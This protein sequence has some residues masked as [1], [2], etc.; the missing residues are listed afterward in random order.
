MKSKLSLLLAAALFAAPI[1]SPLALAQNAQP[2]YN[3]PADAKPAP[4]LKKAKK[5]KKA[6]KGTAAKHGKRSKAATPR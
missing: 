6:K 2:A 4:K 1:T 5:A 3:N